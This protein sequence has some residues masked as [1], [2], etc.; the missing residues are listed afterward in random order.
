MMKQHTT[1]CINTFIEV[2][3][4]CPVSQAQ[5]PPE[6]KEKTLANLQYEKISK[7]PYQYTSDD[8]IFE[9]YAFK[10]DISENEKQEE[11]DQFFSKGQACLRSSPLAKRYG[12]GFHHNKEGKV[13]LYPRESEEYQKLLNDPNITKTKAMRSK[14]K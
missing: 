6:K 8:I 13:A 12:F 14:R 9:C 3:E 5:I 10:K 2:A 1:N 4:D 11:R 7:N